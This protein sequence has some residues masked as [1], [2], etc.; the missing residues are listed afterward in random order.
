MGR[1]FIILGFLLI[2][3][4]SCNLRDPLP[5]PSEESFACRRVRVADGPE[6][7]AL[8]T[9]HGPPRLLVSSH[10]R[11]HPETS[12]GIYFLEIDTDKT[13]ELKRTGEPPLITAFKPHGVDIRHSGNQTLL[14]VIIHDPRGRMERSENA[15]AIY[16]VEDDSL[17]FIQLLEDKEC[18][19]SP[20]DLSVMSSGEIYLTN[21]YKTKFNLYFRTSGS[22]ISYFNPSTRTWSVVAD[23]IAFANGILAEK[24]RVYVTTTLGEEILEYPRN[25]DGTLGKEKK[26]IRVKG[27][28]NLTRQGQYLLTA[29]H[30]DDLAFMRHSKDPAVPSPSVVLRIYPEQRSRAT[31]FVDNG[32]LISAA[33]TA[34]VYQDKL[35]ISQ[36]FDPYIVICSV[37]KFLF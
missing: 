14:Y 20:N 27:P 16:S 25:P 35:Y 7:F 6:D 26:I 22:E 37:P 15:V 8:D 21:D 29:A 36:V 12:G 11:R 3:A 28:D 10:D 5:I 18:L 24:E 23:D 30:F 19:W 17:R 1:V 13:G 34:M 32:E 2:C 31:V 4:I 9:W 33:S